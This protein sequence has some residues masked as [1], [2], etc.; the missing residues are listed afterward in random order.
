[1]R[2]LRLGEVDAL[3][4]ATELEQWHEAAVE[5]EPQ[6]ARLDG[7]LRRQIE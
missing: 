1:M 4:L 2:Q 5:H 3:A 6:R 7:R